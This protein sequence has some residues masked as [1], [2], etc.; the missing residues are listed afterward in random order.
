MGSVILSCR[1]HL[2]PGSLWLHLPVGYVT[3]QWHDGLCK[4]ASECVFVNPAAVVFL[5]PFLMNKLERSLGEGFSGVATSDGIFSS[6]G[7]HLLAF[8]R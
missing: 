8:L 1:E 3:G 5:H 2:D 4:P 7:H 6:S